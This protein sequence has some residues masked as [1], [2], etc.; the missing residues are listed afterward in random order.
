MGG[1]SGG[2]FAGVRWR[3]WRSRAGAAGILPGFGVE[4]QMSLRPTVA[5]TRRQHG[6]WLGRR[7]QWRCVRLFASKNN[8]LTCV[9]KISRNKHE[10]PTSSYNEANASLVFAERVQMAAAREFIWDE[11]RFTSADGRPIFVFEITFRV[12]DGRHMLA[13]DDEEL[14][15]L[16]W[17]VLGQAATHYD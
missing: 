16:H 4:P 13:P 8:G 14:V 9:L 1:G 17:G 6:W 2:R 3:G 10:N 7:V 11:A 12:G 15:K 5:P